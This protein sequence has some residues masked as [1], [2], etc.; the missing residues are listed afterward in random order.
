MTKTNGASGSG[1]GSGG[2]DA[3]APKAQ[4]ISYSLV[5]PASSSRSS[6]GSIRQQR[7]PT[8]QITPPQPLEEKLSRSGPLLIPAV[9]VGPTRGEG[10]QD[11]LD[12]H[13][14]D[15]D[16]NGSRRVSQL[17][18]TATGSRSRLRQ[19]RKHQHSHPTHTLAVTSLALDLTTCVASDAVE[20]EGQLP[21]EDEE[22]EELA[23]NSTT[24][25][26]GSPRPRGIL[27]TAGRDG[28]T[29]SW[30]LNLS[31]EHRASSDSPSEHRADMPPDSDLWPTST[32]STTEAPRW[33]IKQPFWNRTTNTIG[34]GRRMA[35]E[36]V[37]PKTSFR[38]CVQSHT[39]WVNEIVLCNSNQ[40][41]ELL[42]LLPF[43]A[44]TDSTPAA[45]IS[46]SSDRTIKAWNPH[47][48]QSH[49]KPSTVGM[50]DDYVKC[51]AYAPTTS[52]IFSGGFDCCV[53]L[54]D[55]HE[56]RNGVPIFS[57]GSGSSSGIG[58]GTTGAG[59]AGGG[60]KSEIDGSIYALSCDATANTVAIGSTGHIVHIFDTRSRTQIARLTGHTD[61]IKSIL[62]S[63]D[64]RTL[65]SGSSDSTV[66]LWSVA[67][68][69]CLHT[70][71]H[72][73]DSVWSLHSTHDRLDVFYSGDR[74][75]YVCK[76]DWERCAEVEEGE[77]VVLCR[78]TG[79]S[80]GSGGGESSNRNAAAPS[81]PKATDREGRPLNANSSGTGA[82]GK[83]S[84]AALWSKRHRQ[85]THSGI[86]RIV[87]GDDAYFWTASNSSSVKMW[88]DV[89]L[90]SE[91]EAVY[92]GSSAADG[93][94]SSA[95]SPSVAQGPTTAQTHHS[96][97]DRRPSSLRRSVLA[98]SPRSKPIAL[99][100][101][102][103]RSSG[104]GL[105]TVASG[106]GGSPPA[107]SVSF[108]QQNLSS[109][110]S[111]PFGRSTFAS[112]P[113]LDAALLHEFDTS[114][115]NGIPF[116][117][118][119]SLSAANDLYGAAGIGLGSVSVSH[120]RRSSGAGAIGGGAGGFGAGSMLSGHAPAPLGRLSTTSAQALADVSPRLNPTSVRYPAAPG[121]LRFETPEAQHTPPA[122]VFT[123]TSDTFGTWDPDAASHDA[124]HPDAT[125][126]LAELDAYDARLSFE[127]REL[128]EDAEPFQADPVEVLQ[129]SHGLIRS[130]MLN[131][132]RHVLSVDTT[133]NVSVWD[134][135]A[136][137][138]KGAFDTRQVRELVSQ[139]L[140][141]DGKISNGGNSDAQ[142]FELLNHPGDALE[143][144]RDRVEGCGATPLWC[145]VDT[146]AGV[147]TVHLQEPRCF[148]AEMYIDEAD[149]LASAGVKDD[150]R[151]KS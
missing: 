132:R 115:L 146:R 138:C 106:G 65:L 48:A 93:M 151:G 67:E 19:Q 123:A 66:R 36:K 109:P 104:S 12:E 21:E 42:F 10:G 130:S 8:F 99:P 97:D 9:R 112:R 74:Q 119:V 105:S 29:A 18:T 94:T 40:T 3:G 148:D 90:R 113:S 50:H 131:D 95:F 37:K 116:E 128:A 11:G 101:H 27:Y 91:R 121:S 45:V 68:Q 22:Y 71:E 141:A 60:G 72:H 25:G 34:G 15:D 110:P 81:V 82:G 28:L 98:G 7:L 114:Q 35:R 70:F 147:L 134:I 87:A 14:M 77:C 49:L 30:D 47:D 126:A 54:W 79:G 136:G 142:D 83:G 26:S 24:S 58:R 31:I 38:Q 125:A 76:V 5:S 20:E 84:S 56:G 107:H 59:T 17:D 85:L 52:R 64:G 137:V 149:F 4:R 43:S 89:P 144:I 75:G 103:R 145:T 44:R 73:N 46:A 51:L 62:L 117:S 16:D 129:G 55:L 13:E 39:D 23:R 122:P 33:R 135:V 80:S 111:S 100:G 127:E 69:R 92:T 118:L 150:S 41:R 2:G 53:K 108:A 96:G 32:S 139:E 1:S 78:D 57:L 133:G 86:H 140:L 88:I 6:S 124:P 63:P 143:L 61:N 120:R 102:E